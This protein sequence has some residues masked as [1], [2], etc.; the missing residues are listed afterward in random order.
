VSH[1]VVQHRPEREERRVV[2]QNRELRQKVKEL[3]RAV[4]RQQK[5]IDKLQNQPTAD[6]EPARAQPPPGRAPATPERAAHAGGPFPASTSESCRSSASE[7]CCEAPAVHEHDFGGRI[8]LI[9][10]NCRWRRRKDSQ[11]Q[12]G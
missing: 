8:F 9:C 3:E 2:A 4:A 11:F 7:S 10:A 5:L 1:R 6:A 12:V